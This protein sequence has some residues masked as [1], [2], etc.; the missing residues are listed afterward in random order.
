MPINPFW[1][2]IIGICVENWRTL[3]LKKVENQM[4]R[5]DTRYRSEDISPVV[6]SKFFRK[7]FLLLMYLASNQIKTGFGEIYQNILKYILP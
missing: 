7:Q 6:Q 3:R 2:P 4:S 5:H 1:A